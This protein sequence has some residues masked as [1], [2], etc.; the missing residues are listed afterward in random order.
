MFLMFDLC[1]CVC[2]HG[3][4][5]ACHNWIIDGLILNPAVYLQNLVDH[6]Q[7]ENCGEIALIVKTGFADDIL[8]LHRMS[9]FEYL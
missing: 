6:H 3:C 8:D 7:F 2:A 1:V 4:T 5:C 9:N